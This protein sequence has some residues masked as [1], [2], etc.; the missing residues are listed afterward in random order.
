MKQIYK[1]QFSPRTIRILSIVLALAPFISIPIL[2]SQFYFRHDD[3][4]KLL[5]AKEFTQPFYEALSTNPEVNKF[6]NYPGIAGAWRPFVYLYVKALW[7]LFG[8]TSGP[9]YFIGGL[10]FIAAVYF[11]FRL[12]E[13]RSGMLAAVLSCLALFAV[14]HGSM[15]NLFLLHTAVSFFY[16]LG[17]IYFFW[18]FLKKYSW[19]NLV[20]MLL[21]LVPAMS[22]QT[23]PIILI[24]ILVT[25]LFEH[26]G[27]LSNFS[28]R[29]YL[30]IL[31][32]LMAGFFVITFSWSIGRISVLAFASDYDKVLNYLSERFFY[33]G[34]ILTSGITGSIMLLVFGGGVF[35]H[36]AQKAKERFKFKKLDWMWPPVILIVTFLLMLHQPYAIYWFVLCCLYLFIFDDELRMPIGWALASLFLF[37]MSIYYHNGYLLGA[38]FPFAMVIGILS[39]RLICRCKNVWEKYSTEQ[40]K[41]LAMVGGVVV[42]TILVFAIP[43]FNKAV[44]LT[45]RIDAIKLTIEANNN[46]K[47]LMTYLQNEVPKDATLY[48][49]AEREIGISPSERR[50]F[51]FKVQAQRTKIM[52]ISD[53]LTMLKVL[54]RG[55]I[56]I[57]RASILNN[58]NPTSED[59]F[60][61]LN[62]YEKETTK[63]HFKLVPIKEFKS[64]P[65]M[66][67]VYRFY[68]TLNTS[69]K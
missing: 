55:D 37:L 49:Y 50:K 1:I 54:D 35:H 17:M 34:T 68:Y 30:P 63:Q 19:Y 32:I 39:A 60:M 5:W 46:F 21:F 42:F 36:L 16:Q 57:L 23:T 6:D 3:S 64:E 65:E 20:G 52:N 40:L 8:T 66:A 44:F 26:R 61:T 24:A 9:Y 45:D 41:K 15:Y 53:K 58:T 67:S 48:E 22:R 27:S 11:L 43:F 51:S 25:F 14:F 29:K 10:F 18:C 13:K 12:V 38:G 31:G 56:N 59:F 62:N 33:Y 7:H 2:G 4:V 47:Q 28:L 69:L